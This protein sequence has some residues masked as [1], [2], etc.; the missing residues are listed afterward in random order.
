MKKKTN[1]KKKKEERP[2]SFIDMALGEAQEKDVLPEGEYDLI[3]EGAENKVSDKGKKMISIRHSVDGEPNARTVFH[4]LNLVSSD[5]DPDTA[6]SKLLFAIAYLKAFEIPYEG[7]GFNI[8]DFPGARG[9]VKL[10]QK[11]Y[12]GVISNEIKLSF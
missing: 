11:E 2:M 6:N 10:A 9:R 7:A 1:L 4:N 5:D 8:D 3:I 12:N